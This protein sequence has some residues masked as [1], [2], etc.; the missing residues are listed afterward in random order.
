MAGIATSGHQLTGPYIFELASLSDDLELRR[1]LRD[2]PMEGEAQIAFEREPDFF[3]AS[4]LM[5]TLHQTVVARLRNTRRII[6]MGSRSVRAMYLDGEVKNVG[7]LSELR[8]DKAQRGRHNL[9]RKGYEMGRTLHEDRATPFY[10]TSIVSDNAPARRL[11]EAGLVGMPTYTFLCTYQT[12]V[13]PTH[14]FKVRRSKMCSIATPDSKQCIADCLHR[15]YERYAWAPYWDITEFGSM[16]RTP[17][18]ATEDFLITSQGSRITGC[19]ALWDQRGFRQIVVR[20]YSRRLARWRPFLNLCSSLTGVP[21]LPPCGKPWAY[22]Y[23][24]PMA[25]DDDNPEL[26]TR[27]LLANLHRAPTRGYDY[28]I[29]GLA[30][31]HPLLG[32][33]RRSIRHREYTSHLYLVTWDGLPAQL[34]RLRL[35]VPHPEVALL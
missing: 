25:I 31:T 1:L 16:E 18:L 9:I 23:V 3:A 20:G 28:V 2:N 24:S 5:G 7:Y 34:D 30:E 6:G 35:A 22:A 19:M 17:G 32:V 27:L 4:G 13:I 26:F 33:A 8:V 15:S 12:L 21:R 10:L 29:L 11:L 14:S